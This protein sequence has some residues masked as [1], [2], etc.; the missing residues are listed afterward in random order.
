MSNSKTAGTLTMGFNGKMSLAL[1][2]DI[3]S[4]QKKE[5]SA[6]TA[7]GLVLDRL[8][9][10]GWTPEDFASGTESREWIKQ[11]IT[12]ALYNKAGL[13]RYLGKKA[14]MKAEQWDQRDSEQAVVSSK[15][16]DYKVSLEKRLVKA[17]LIAQGVD[18]AEAVKQASEKSAAEKLATMLDSAKKLLLNP[19][20]ELPKGFK[21]Q[22]HISRLNDILADLGKTE[23]TH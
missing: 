17:E 4:H 14:D 20:N 22:Q 3:E 11:R 5:I 18:P 1:A 13:N 6:M 8:E 9:S 12:L 21:T 16:R 10:D 7:R 15:L 2:K 19:E 23:P